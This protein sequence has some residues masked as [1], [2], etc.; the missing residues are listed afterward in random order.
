LTVRSNVSSGLDGL[1]GGARVSPFDQT[2][3]S[4][5]RGPLGYRQ[6][7]AEIERINR[8]RLVAAGL[9][10]QARQVP[11]TPPAKVPPKFRAQR[12]NT[13]LKR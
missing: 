3:G 1:V 6:V 13:G 9:K 5:G 7:D 12:R 2:G 10:R 4:D 11:T 8:D